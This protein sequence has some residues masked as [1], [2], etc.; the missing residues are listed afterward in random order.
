VLSNVK[1]A[2]TGVALLRYY[3]STNTELVAASNT[4]G[5]FSNCT[6]RIHIS[7]SAAVVTGPAPFTQD[8]DAEIRNR[9][10][11]GIGC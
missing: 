6:V 9:L 10:P 7:V 5:D 11:G 2:S 3:N 1:N 8:L 4:P